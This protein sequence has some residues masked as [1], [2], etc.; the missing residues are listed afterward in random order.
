MY[1]L[2]FGFFMILSL[3][4]QARLKSKVRKYSKEFL[5]SGLTGREI[6]EKMLHDHGIYD[7]KVQCIKGQLTDHYNPTNKTLNLSEDVYNGSHVAA[8]AVAAHECGHAVQ[9]QEAYHWLGLR[10][11]LVPFANIGGTLSTWVIL[12]GLVL[13]SVLAENQTI[14]YAVTLIGI[15]LYA[16][17]TIFTFVT[18]P[19]EYNASARAL[20]WLENSGLVSG[21]MHNDAKDA[22][23]WAARTYV[24]AALASLATLL[25]YIS[26]LNRR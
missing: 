15:G 9:H 14:G 5:P 13:L 23:K 24:V 4:V 20:S 21:A 26:L 3:I 18:L 2:I 10:S 19:V 12:G 7:V 22:L 6:A 1:W 16:L 11:A 25:Y 17:T 8:A